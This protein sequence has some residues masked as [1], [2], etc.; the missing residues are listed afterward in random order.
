M[1]SYF[2]TQWFRL[3]VGLACMAGAI[4]YMFQS[5]GDQTVLEGLVRNLDNL[6][7]S[8]LWWVSSLTWLISSVLSWHDDCLEKLNKRVKALEAEYKKEN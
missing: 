4:H 7:L 8:I 2:K 3:L 1:V 6:A 5:I